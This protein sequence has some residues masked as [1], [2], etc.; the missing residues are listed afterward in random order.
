MQEK[1]LLVG[2]TTLV[3]IL[4]QDPLIGLYVSFP[5][6]QSNVDGD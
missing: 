6:S 1:Y 4:P 5:H 2:L 3:I